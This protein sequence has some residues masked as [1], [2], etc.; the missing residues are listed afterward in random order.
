MSDTV[1]IG[2]NSDADTDVALRELAAKRRADKSVILREAVN[3]YLDTQQRPHGGIEVALLALVGG[4]AGGHVSLAEGHAEAMCLIG[5]AR[6]D[7][8]AAVEAERSGA[9]DA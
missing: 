6:Q 3:A 2:F 5:R 9:G 8:R 1:F 4:L 7:T